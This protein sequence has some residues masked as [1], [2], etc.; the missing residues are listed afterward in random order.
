MRIDFEKFPDSLVPAIVQD[1]RTQMVLMLGFMNKEA[2]ERT[3]SSGRAT[4]FSRSRGRLWVKGE[5]SGNFLSVKK[6]LWDC[7]SDT[8]LIRAIPAGPVCHTGADTC[9]CEKN[10]REDF[11]FELEAI[12][13][14]RRDQPRSGSYTAGLFA[15]GVNRIAQKVGEEAVELIIEAK[16]S[17]VDAFKNE[18]ADLLFHLLVLFSEK[19]VEL[20]EVLDIL[21]S[22]AG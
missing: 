7:D 21:R 9:F 6:L 16:N 11:L 22:R 15:S 2:Y 17:D 14:D 18:A 19:G 10:R 5:T 4:F 1:D 3:A 13:Q 20:K 8:V 12:I